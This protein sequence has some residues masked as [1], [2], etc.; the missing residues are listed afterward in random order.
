MK[1]FSV[2]RCLSVGSFSFVLASML[3]FFPIPSVATVI[4]IGCA[5]TN[6]SCT[7]AELDAGGAVVINDIYFHDFLA[8]VGI[9]S[10]PDVRFTFYDSKFSPGFL[11]TRDES[12]PLFDVSG[13]PVDIND[14]IGFNVDSLGTRKIP[15]ATLGAAIGDYNDAASAYVGASVAIG[16]TTVL[17]AICLD[18]L[19]CAHST[20]SDSILFDSSLDKIEN[21]F[22]S[23]IGYIANESGASRSTVQL[24][25]IGFRLVPEPGIVALMCLGLPAFFFTRRNSTRNG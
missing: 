15:R 11:I 19:T 24:D 17:S 12:L 21:I 18:P 8:P 22:I 16:G 10:D 7:G 3:I 20:V 14:A 4:T 6:R 25:A 9:F 1:I 23:G 2:M 13:R 5:D